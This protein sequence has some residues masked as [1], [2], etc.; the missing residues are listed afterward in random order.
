MGKQRS[1]VARK[2]LQIERDRFQ[3]KAL[4]GTGGMGEV[5][6]AQDLRRVEWGDS[7]PRVAIKRLLPE[8]RENKQAQLALAQ[9]FFLLRHLVHPGIVRTFDIHQQS[10]GPCYSMELLD[11]SALNL[12]DPVLLTKN[13]FAIAAQLFDVLSFL[14]AHGIIHGDIKPANLFF[15]AGGRLTLIDFNIATA[16]SRPGAAASPVGKGIAGD[17]RLPGYSALHASPDCLRGAAPRQ[18]DDVFS[19]C[20]T[21]YESIAGRHP[22]NRHTSLEAEEQNLRPTKPQELSR[23]AWKLLSAGLAF[24]GAARPDAEALRR[25]FSGKQGSVLDRFLSYLQRGMYGPAQSRALHD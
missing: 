24:D 18:P 21:V 10:W 2:Q 12:C 23:K 15:A 9:E 11:G 22:F 3:L 6:A 5:Y 8:L 1:N 16:Q 13:A 7:E 19:A 20:C 4:L 25:A 14:H 17:L